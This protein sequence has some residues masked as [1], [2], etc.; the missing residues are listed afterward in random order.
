MRTNN[1]NNK[2]LL[3]T[4]IIFNKNH[5]EIV[6]AAESFG[7]PYLNGFLD[8]VGSNFS[9]GAN[10]ATA[11]STIRPQTTIYYSPFSLK[12]Q[13]NQFYDF[14]QRSQIFR[15][16]EDIFKKLLPKAEYFSEALYTF[17]IGQNDLV[18]SYFPNMSIDQVKAAI[19]DM[20]DQFK[21]YAKSMYEQG[22]RYY[23]IHNTG[24]LGCLPYVLDGLPLNTQM[25]PTGCSIPINEFAQYFN[26]GLKKTVAQLREDMPLASI[27]YVDVYSIKYDL[28]S[29]ANKYG[30]IYPLKACCGQGGKYNYDSHKGCGA[31]FMDHGKEI[32]VGACNNPLVK[33]SWDGAHY[34]DAANKW[35]FDRLADGSYSDPPIS[36]KRA[37][38]KD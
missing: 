8:S 22:A 33:I 30:F 38:Y 20:L 35:I 17:D 9:H 25:D 5:H 7:L 4:P 6:Y 31:R 16:K 18:A 19:P 27:T 3:L 32:L 13:S 11:G 21:K 29:N 36:L 15:D 14:H 10:F 34:T 23:W 28:I 12:I 37:C 1:N 24:P 2:I 26:I